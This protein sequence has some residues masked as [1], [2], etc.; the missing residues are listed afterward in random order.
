MKILIVNDTA[1]IIG[2]AASV[3]IMTARILADA[4]HEVIFFAA[5]SKADESLL[6]NRNIHLVL[7]KQPLF[8]D[9]PSRI[10]G[11]AMGLYNW[12]AKKMLLECIRDNPDIQIAHI[13]SWTKA[14]SSSIFSALRMI[15]IPTVLTA[16]DYFLCCPNG[17]FFNYKTCKICLLKPMSV[18]CLA[19]N[20]DRRSY[21]QKI[22]RLIRTAIQNFIFSKKFPYVI[23]VSEFA[24][25]IIVRDKPQAYGTVIRNPVDCK[26]ITKVDCSSNHVYAYFG[27]VDQ[28]KDV[29]LFC[30]AVSQLGLSGRVIGTGD[31]IDQLS[32][33]Y[34]NIEFVGWLSKRHLSEYMQDVRCCVFPSLWYETDG[35]TVKEIM[36]GWGIPVIGSDRTSVIE[37]IK[38]GVD[39]LLFK[40]GDIDSLK[41]QLRKS[42]DDA[43]IQSLQETILIERYHNHYQTQESY[44]NELLAVYRSCIG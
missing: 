34:P 25:N 35:L 29:G 19:S 27:R 12:Y 37:N 41:L 40:T 4:G 38:D 14:L 33:K 1:T 3:A 7:T 20:C 22:Y 17:G 31:Q 5:G 43:L 26:H 11:A 23:H 2:G 28:E 15:N 32:R 8:F 39:G 36:L 6:S 21:A 13:H 18:A 10:K 9:N 16:H 42:E 30:E 24:R 44:L